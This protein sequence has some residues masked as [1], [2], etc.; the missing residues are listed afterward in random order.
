MSFS[1]KSSNGQ[2][3]LRTR[4]RYLFALLKLVLAC[5][6][7]AL[8]FQRIDTGQMLRHLSSLDIPHVL[9]VLSLMTVAN[10]LSAERMRYYFL[11]IGTRLEHKKA[12]LIYY[13]GAFY[14]FLL[15]GSIGGDL[16][17]LYVLKRYYKISAWS[18]LRTQLSDRAS[19][20]FALMAS[21][22]VII[23]F[24]VVMDALELSI[25]WLIIPLVI[26]VIS[27]LYLVNRLLKEKLFTALA[28]FRY[29]LPVTITWCLAYVALWYSLGGDHYLA[30]EIFLFQLA[31][32]LAIVPVTP[33]GLGMREL[34][35]F[36][37]S[38]WLNQYAGTTIDPSFCIAISLYFFCFHLMSSLPGL[39]LQLR[40][41]RL[42]I[43]Q[44]RVE[45]QQD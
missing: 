12:W 31:L 3:H 24:T 25:E 13:I 8:V 35:L 34:V 26:L 33:G 28:A 10:L 45:N 5:I 37:G 21:V 41:H 2:P 38:K 30:E 7:L 11:S 9:L 16:Y 32:V 15:P 39:F 29:S 42:T 23:P 36:Y 4:R 6:L 17:R 22:I 14:N 1:N 44:K 18:A 20:L 27:Y 43:D 19:G 40:E